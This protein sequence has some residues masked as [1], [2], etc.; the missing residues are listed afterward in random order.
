MKKHLKY[1]KSKLHFNGNGLGEV[2]DK[3]E[4][5][6]YF[7][8]EALILNNYKHFYETALKYDIP[9]PLVCFALKSNPNSYII[10]SLAKSG[11]GA[12]IVSGGELELALKCGVD[13]KKIVF[14]GVGKTQKEIKQ[15]I[16]KGILSFNVESEDELDV[17]NFY[18]TKLK[19]RAQVAFRLNPV[20]HAKT[21]KYISTGYKNHKFGLLA[22]DI[23]RMSKKKKYWS[24]TSLIGLST[25][26]GS[27]LTC[28]K[29]TRKAI[30]EVFALSF[31]ISKPFDFL[32][33]GG[34]LGIPYKEGEKVTS[35]D[36][37]MK[38]VSKGIVKNKMSKLVDG[39]KTRIVFEPGRVLV[40]EGGVL[41]TKVIRTKPGGE[42]QF[43][44]VD[45]GMSDLLR[46]SLYSAHHD[47]LP[48]S[49]KKS[50]KVQVDIVGPIC[51]SADSFAKNL[52]LSAPKKDDYFII[53]DTGA[54][55]ISM[56]SN[57]NV[58]PKPKEVIFTKNK[59]YK[60]QS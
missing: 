2:C 56:A 60:V 5:P 14:S 54:Y 30:D 24:N 47:I 37:Y 26:I 19:K 57:Y 7:Y 27:Q 49:Q 41:I 28:M 44:I 22:Q 1:S 53:A 29:A 59:K 6:F 20:V 15:G 55:G 10:S 21:H 8:D 38:E 12:D 45:A 58:R 34:G 31:E 17:I 16:L 23:I 3:Y 43:A 13:P 36:E 48:L 46:P 11:A 32:D 51:E 25:H 40:G 50:K 35:V 42:T 9:N 33:F 39:E 18:S 4:T 52:K